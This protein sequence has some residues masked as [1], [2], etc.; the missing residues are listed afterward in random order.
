M[1]LFSFIAALL[2][3]LPARA[4]PEHP[5]LFLQKGEEAKLVANIKAD[6]R[7]TKVHEAILGESEKLLSQD[8]IV[9]KLNARKEMHHIGCEAVR[10]MLF[11]AY[12][13]RTTGDRRFLDKAVSQASDICALSSWNPYHFLDVAEITLAATIAYDWLYDDISPELRKR[14]QES[15]VEKALET[16]EHGGAGNPVY[17]LRWMDMTSNWSQIC[18]GSMAMAALALKGDIEDDALCE[19]IIE[20]STDKMSIPMEAEYRP[21]GAYSQGIG[22][23]GYGTAMNVMFLDAMEKCLGHESVAGLEAI[24]GFMNTGKYFSQLLTNT[25]DSF[26]FSDNSTGDNL[27]EHCIFWFYAKTHDATLLYPQKAMIDRWVG[28]PEFVSGPYA[29]HDPLM[30]IWGAGIGDGPCADFD[31]AKQPE[32]LFYIARGLNPICTMR[33]GWGQDDIWL[34]FKAGNPSCPHGHMD[35]G[36]FMLE[37]GGVRWAEDLGSDRY[38][39]FT[40]L[41]MGSLFNMKQESLRW[42]ELLRYNNFSH[43]TLTFNGAFQNL[44]TKA[45]FTEHGADK[46][47]MYAVADLGP[48]YAGQVAGAKRRV[49]LLEGSRI[50]IVDTIRTESYKPAS[51]VWNMTTRAEGF[52]YDKDSGIITLEGKN[53]QGEIKVMK[54]KVSLGNRKASPAG[55][56]VSR[57]AVADEFRYPKL[58]KPA[59]GC[60]FIRIK[61]DI[62]KGSTQ[63]MKV[64]M[65]KKNQQ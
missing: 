29:R 65:T 59:P 46:D 10:R 57:I 63:T 54:M 41:K 32:E 34:G 17:N 16:S 33:S 35:V 22:Y 49:A 38:G 39:A 52:S 43:N 56:K 30:V 2:L 37:W 19:R 31:A 28:S 36:E 48:T 62:K 44:E 40:V 15:I 9:F 4:L 14:L 26:S 1:R 50:E 47:A 12:S 25:L 42:N 23:W 61:Y 27:P 55:I 60:W 24:P 8:N 51:V 64:E 5:R 13:Y 11:L 58:E 6:A 20:R 53:A 45:E 18:H 7:W 3:A 21:D